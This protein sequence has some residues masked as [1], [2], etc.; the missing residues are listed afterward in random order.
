MARL[1]S[2]TSRFWFDFR[3]RLRQSCWEVLFVV[4]VVIGVRGW[5]VSCS[6]AGFPCCAPGPCTSVATGV[7][8]VAGVH[9]ST[10]NLGRPTTLASCRNAPADMVGD[11]P[12]F[13]FFFSSTSFRVG[14]RVGSEEPLVLTSPPSL[15]LIND[16][17]ELL[18]YALSKLENDGVGEGSD[19]GTAD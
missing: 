7:G 17:P 19:S 3:D 15:D 12:P 9:S 16:S 10:P 14:E 2:V 6:R 11:M 18:E 4:V 8:F 1:R 5:R 13:F